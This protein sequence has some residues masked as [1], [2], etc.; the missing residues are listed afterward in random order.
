[1]NRVKFIDRMAQ[2]KVSRR[3]MLAAAGSFGVGVAGLPMRVR[4]GG[5]P[6][7]FEWTGYDIPELFPPYMEKYG[8][9]PDFAIF[10]DETE[11]LQKVRAGFRPDLLHPC[12]DTVVDF[13]EAGFTKPIDTARLSHWKD[14]IPALA[15]TPG[16]VLGGEVHMTP[17]D[18]GNSSLIYRTDLV[19][20][21]FLENESWSIIFDDRY[22]GRVA[23]RAGDVN[24]QIAGLVLGMSKTE[25]FHMTDEQIASTRPLLEKLAQVARVFWDDPSEF[26]QSMAAGEI[27]VAYAWNA[28]VKNLRAMGVPVKYAVPKEGMLTWLCGLTILTNGEGDEGM[29]YDFLDAWLSPEA[30]KFLIEEYGYGHGNA[31]SFEAAAPESIADLGFSADPTEMM[32][33]SVMFQPVPGEIRAKYINLMDEVLAAAGT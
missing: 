19:E 1:M 24:V 6:L 29:I 5:T 27:V 22:T 10:G 17:C 30:G 21:D 23:T 4:A 25:V 13:Y 16:V 26:E 20:P 7:V 9:K 18:W 15:T 11:A 31:K 12:S 33:G 2:G 8:A 32:A 3:A 14:V 28:A